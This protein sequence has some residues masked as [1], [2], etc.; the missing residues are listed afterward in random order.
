MKE[1]RASLGLWML[2]V[3]LSIVVVAPVQAANE[4]MCKD[5]YLPPASNKD[6]PPPLKVTGTCTVT[7]GMTYY[8]ENVNVLNGG[9]LVFLDSPFGPTDTH[10]WT[11]SII[12]EAGGTLRA[13]GSLDGKKR[14]V[15]RY[16]GQFGGTLWIHIWGSNEADWNPTTQKFNKQNA[17][18]PCKTVET[19]E[20]GPC[21]VPQRIW[22]TNGSEPVELPGRLT[23]G[24]LIDYFYQYG[25]LYGDGRCKDNSSNFDRGACR[26]GGGDIVKD[27]KPT[28]Y[29]GNKV[30][31]VSYGATVELEGYKGVT[32][33]MV[34]DPASSGVSWI[35]LADGHSL[36]PQ[37][38]SLML[39]REPGDKWKKGD[40]IVVTTTDYLPGHSEKLRI[41]GDF[42]DNKDSEYR[43]GAKVNFEAFDTPTNTTKKLEWWHNGVRYGGRADTPARR[44]NTET[45]G[46]LPRRLRNSIANDLTWTG[47]ETRAAVAL[48]S[49]SIKIVSGGDKAGVL[50]P[51][52]NTNGPSYHYGAHMVI[53]QGFEHLHI[54]GVEFV[55]M[56]QGGRLGHYPVHF[57]MARKTPFWTVIKDSAV[58]ESMNRWFV[59]HSTQNVTLARNVGYK[60]IGHGYYLESGTESDNQLYSNIGI[61]ARAAVENRQNER[62]VPG[63][64]A[65]NGQDKRS[66]PYRSD[67]E[68]PT[69]FWISNGWNDFIGNM[70]AGAGTCGAAYWLVP[71]VNSDMV[72]VSEDHRAMDWSLSGYA[73]LQKANTPKNNL[74]QGTTPL[75][76]FYKNTATSAMFSFQT[77]GDG[78]D[79]GGVIAADATDDGTLPRLKAVRSIAPPPTPNY[80][81]D[82]Y[83]PYT[84]GGSRF[85]T[86]C[87]SDG[88][89]GHDCTQI[90]QRCEATNLDHCTATVLD[91]F[92]SSF[93]W[94]EGNFSAIWL[95]PQWY[96]LVDSVITDVQNG[97]LTFITGGDYTHSSIVRGYWALA[98]NTIFVGNTNPNPDPSKPETKK[99]AF[100]GNVGPFNAMSGLKCDVK[101]QLPAY[102]LNANEGITMPTVGFFTNQRLSNIYDGPSYQDSNAYLDITT[103][104]CPMWKDGDQGKKDQGCMYGS[105][106]AYLR[107][108]R[109]PGTTSKDDL[110]LCRT[111]GFAYLPNAAIAWKQPN[112]FYY[113]PAFHSKNLFFDNVDLRHY[114]INPLFESNTYLTNE[115]AVSKEYCRLA[116]GIFRTW[117]SIDRQ[118]ELTDDDGSLTGLSNNAQPTGTAKQTISVNDDSFFNA[119]VE[120]AECGSATGP[121]ATPAAAC[122]PLTIGQPTATAKTSPYEYLS[123]VIY[124]KEDGGMWDKE[125]ANPG[126]YGV[127]LFRQYLTAQE[128]KDWDKD[129]G[130]TASKASDKCRWPFIRMAGVD[131]GQRQTMTMNNGKYYID[132]TVSLPRQQT[133]NYFDSGQPRR[134]NV[135]AENQTYYV[136]FLY[137]RKTTSQVY[138]IYVGENFD[139]P[140]QGGKFSVGRMR[141]P[142]SNMT[143][144]EDSSTPGITA[145][146][147]GGI[148]TVNVDF[149]NATE[150]EPT[151]EE[152]CHPRNFCKPT[153]DK[154]QCE[155]AV[156]DDDPMFRANFRLKG[157]IRVVCEDWGMKDLDCPQKGC[158]GF[159]ITLP[160]GFAAGQ[161]KRPDPKPFPGMPTRFSASTIPTDA[162][163]KD[164][165][166]YD[167]S[168][169]PISE[170][171]TPVSR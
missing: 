4:V 97:G 53:R 71:A 28:G 43:G 119:P 79:C 36:D 144:V 109:K 162:T 140:D 124:R 145:S 19:E 82:H 37:A 138:Q 80:L 64:L 120:T 54:S 27:M 131:T 123:T 167:P 90:K 85:A 103:A 171:C 77:V 38:S 100:A 12:V 41:V 130:T 45:D 87:P 155:I 112:G 31:A 56:G 72:D 7:R 66:F 102:C 126:C 170:P 6:D 23:T 83:Y 48:L 63:I 42:P 113:P 137:A 118:T 68:T 164:L 143:F 11:S 60:S 146:F 30:L 59:L 111:P 132:T 149:K 150:L 47:A 161:Y 169:K 104:D 139:Q 73:G 35:R 142:D 160:K 81:D 50:F 58:N 108:K 18:T 153:R 5:I 29:F 116:G 152:L 89:G 33:D 101:A 105:N 39:E 67:V 93:H 13:T 110:E 88:K 168:K 51:A 76:S 70:A 65:Y 122:G 55:Q 92:T 8:Y 16:Y 46:R 99:Y 25:P 94:A 26:N 96:L 84:V 129:C 49:R 15:G 86:T 163:H 34:N 62:K 135:F 74:M 127:P 32:F 106:S 121:N 9:E 136:F 14:T 61:F 134:F 115:T 133:E 95:R 148:L 69:V 75:K 24:K 125:C 114:V 151:A 52:V 157:Q 10:F 3:A 91:H 57:H 98:R 22:K 117:T 147:E 44:F 156:A 21:G 2:A 154:K 165:C 128:M 1:A 40:E 159:A 20:I 78:P 107:L 141:I 17:G 166:Y 158:L